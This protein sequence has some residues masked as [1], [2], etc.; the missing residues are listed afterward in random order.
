MKHEIVPTDNENYQSE[1]EDFD[2]SEPPLDPKE[3]A[4]GIKKLGYCHM[5]E[6]QILVS[7]LYFEIC[8]RCI[9]INT[10]LSSKQTFS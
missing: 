9:K 4:E 3:L 8:Q 2:F 7:N 10:R 6:E 1:L 5:S